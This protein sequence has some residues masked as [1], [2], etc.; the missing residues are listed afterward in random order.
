MLPR[1]GLHHLALLQA[2]GD[3]SAV[4]HAAARLG[5]TQSAASHRLREAE[6][7]I[8]AAL[9]HRGPGGVTLTPEGWRLARF[10]GR[11]LP[12]LARLE[13]EITVSAGGPR[14]LVRLGQATYSRY[15]WL[16]A[17]VR[18]LNDT[19][20]DLEL[21]LS[22]EATARPLASLMEGRVDV[23]TIYGRPSTS[24]R[25]AW[26]RLATDPLVAVMAPDH[27]L[28]AE[29]FVDTTRLADTRVYSYPFA[30]EPGFEWEALLGPPTQP[31]RRLTGM[32]T[33]EAVI[34]LVR[35][36]FGVSFFSRWAVEPEIAAGTLIDRPAS[37][38]GFTLDWWAVT[39]AGEEGRD[40][41]AG[42]L[43]AALT[44]WGGG[45]G[46]GLATLGFDEPDPAA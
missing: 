20:P 44:A 46:P 21:D 26:A 33:P 38:E 22:A 34:D 15:H 39:R 24:R 14:R 9:V 32:A 5:V 11:A 28:A 45:H 13:Q 3:T 7:R 18:F 19:E 29:P 36:G 40:C 16:P 30:T 8:G 37:P 42:R 43:V 4:A 6:R 17:F 35:A 27:P 31:L 10:A 23:S 41:P 2:I 25:F 1:L 12:E